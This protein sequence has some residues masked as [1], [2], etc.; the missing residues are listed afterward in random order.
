MPIITISGVIGFDVEPKDIRNQLKD[1]KGDITVEIGSP[2]G[3]VFDGLEIFNLLRDYTGGKVTTKLMGIAAS[4]ASYIALAGDK[5]I[6][7]DNAI[8]MIHNAQSFAIGDQHDMREMADHIEAMSNHLAKAYVAKTGKSLDEIKALMDDD[9]FF[10]GQEAVDAGFVDEII[11]TEDKKDKDSALIE[12]QAK[13]SQCVSMMKELEHSKEDMQ[14]AAACLKTNTPIKNEFTLDVPGK[15]IKNNEEGKK[16]PTLQEL[17]A[18][19]PGAKAEHDLVIAS[20]E[21]T[22]HEKGEKKI[23]DRINGAQNYLGNKDYPE[24]ISALAKS[25]I[26]GEAELISLTASVTAVDAVLQKEVSTEAK[27][28][29]EE[30]GETTPEVKNTVNDTGI[31]ETNEEFEAELKRSKDLNGVK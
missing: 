28:E 22:G 19:N 2:G 12:A 3:F 5:V 4:M 26:T 18:E 9:T 6:M 8:Y 11:E 15:N 16:M 24:S 27:K 29:T 10:F 23:T 21:K 25:V 17:L 13:V 1:A 20:A 14:K 7:H 30:M 31:C